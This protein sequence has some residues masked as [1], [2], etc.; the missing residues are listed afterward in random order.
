LESPPALAHRLERQLVIFP[1]H[2]ASPFQGCGF[3][4]RRAVARSVIRYNRGA[5]RGLT[6]RVGVGRAGS[7]VTALGSV[8][9]YLS[10]R[11]V[12]AMVTTAR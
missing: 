6:V 4:K 9:S 10:H 11:M 3:G 7:A 5:F 1:S 12:A 2:D 8:D